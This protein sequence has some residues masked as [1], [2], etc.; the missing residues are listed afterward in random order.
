MDS[1]PCHPYHLGCDECDECDPIRQNTTPATQRQD[2][3][4]IL[5][6]KGTGALPQGFPDGSFTF[7]CCFVARPVQRNG[8]PFVLDPP[9]LRRFRSFRCTDCATPPPFV[10]VYV[11]L[12]LPYCQPSGQV[13][14]LGTVVTYCHVFLHHRDPVTGDSFSQGSFGLHL[15]GE[16]WVA[17]FGPTHWHD[18]PNSYAWNPLTRSIAGP[19]PR[20]HELS[21]AVG[22]K[23]LLRKSGRI[24]VSPHAAAR[25]ED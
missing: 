9:R 5:T 24:G 18:C 21:T 11:H 15:S 13:A 25:H 12:T 22:L 6:N 16:F 3:L 2:Q 1:I 20:L 17:S 19:H 14:H 4:F 23:R 8:L 7:L 10:S